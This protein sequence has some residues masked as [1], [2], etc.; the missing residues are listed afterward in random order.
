MAVK[1]EEDLLVE[2]GRV[3]RV[4]THDEWHH[5]SK[6]IWMLFLRYVYKHCEI[7][8]NILLFGANCPFCYTL[9][10]FIQKITTGKCEIV[11]RTDCTR[12]TSSK[13]T[14]NSRNVI[15]IVVL[16]AI[17]SSVVAFE[18]KLYFVQ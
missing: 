14:N 5:S 4:C 16:L 13:C 7:R 3:K 6:N 12:S 8:M 17:R 11:N 10:N 1:I 18:R 2:G 15:N 9:A